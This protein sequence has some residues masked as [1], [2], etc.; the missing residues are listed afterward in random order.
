M[1]GTEKEAN[2]KATQS[3]EDQGNNANSQNTLE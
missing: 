2:L 1:P 3:I